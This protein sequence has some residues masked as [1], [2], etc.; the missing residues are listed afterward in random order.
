MFA[1]FSSRKTFVWVM[2]RPEIRLAKRLIKNTPLDTA[3]KPQLDRLLKTPFRVVDTLPLGSNTD[4]R[5]RGYPSSSRI[6][7][8]ECLQ[9]H[10]KSNGLGHLDLKC[11]VHGL[12]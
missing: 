12:Y 11:T 8:N 3:F 6:A 4:H 1:A 10:V 2:R 7:P 9:I 5:A